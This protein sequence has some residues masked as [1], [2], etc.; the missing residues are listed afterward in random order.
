MAPRLFL[1]GVQAGTRTSALG[2]GDERL[3]RT[4]VVKAV[5]RRDRCGVPLLVED[6]PTPQWQIVT[7]RMLSRPLSSGH[8]D[9]RSGASP[10]NLPAMCG[11]VLALKVD[12][13]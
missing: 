2:H 12:H 9:G 1:R 13:E 8:A 10:L 3:V 6:G 7:A 4:E 11:N 5:P